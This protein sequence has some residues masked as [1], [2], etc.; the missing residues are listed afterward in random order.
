[1][2]ASVEGSNSVPG[3]AALSIVVQLVN[4]RSPV[5]SVDTL[6]DS[7]QAETTADAPPGTF[8]AHISASDAN[9]GPNGHVTCRLDSHAD[10]FRLVRM[11]DGEYKM[12]T[13]RQFN[14]VGVLVVCVACQDHGDPP[15]T[16]FT[17][18]S[19][20]ISTG[21]SPVFTQPV[22]NASISAA[23]LTPAFVIRVTA[24]EPKLPRVETLTYS[25]EHPQPAFTINRTTGL[26]LDPDFN[27]IFM[28]FISHK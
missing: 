23:A 19:V 2:E 9:R 22:Y 26:C 17:N 10:H 15:L 6:T 28:K 16:T 8:I 13:E 21:Q 24:T 18:V 25:F 11:F 20:T 27:L 4:D 7:G 14:V 1:M 12:L 5:V 3:L